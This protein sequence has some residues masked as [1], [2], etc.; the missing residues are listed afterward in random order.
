MKPIFKCVMFAFVFAC[1]LCPAWAQE[2]E[3]PQAGKAIEATPEPSPAADSETQPEASAEAVAEPSAEPKPDAEKTESAAAEGDDFSLDSLDELDELEQLESLDEAE[4]AEE[5]Q[6]KFFEINGYFRLRADLFHNIDLGIYDKLRPITDLPTDN[7]NINDNSA[8]DPFRRRRDN[9]IASTNMRLRLSPI[10]NISEDIKI[11]M[12]IDILDN[13]VLGTTPD[14]YRHGSPGTAP[15]IAG[16]SSSQVPPRAGSNSHTDSIEVKRVWAEVRTPFGLIKFGRMPSHWGTGM[17]INDGNCLDCDYGDTVDRILFGTK[18]F[19]HVLFFGYDFPNEGLTNDSNFEYGGQNLD[20]TQL[21]DVTQLVFGFARKHSDAEAEELIENNDF[22]IDYGFYNVIRWQS[23]SLESWDISPYGDYP[24]AGDPETVF[25]EQ[26]MLR[27]K[28]IKRNLKVYIGDLWFKFL[29][30]R[31]H[32]ETEAA[33]LNGRIGS[34]QLQSGGGDDESDKDSLQ[35]NQYGWVLQADYKFL[36]DSLFVGAE[37]GWAS[38]DPYHAQELEIDSGFGVYPMKD[39]QYANGAYQRTKN[40]PYLRDRAVENFRF[41]PD[42]I[43]DMI[44]FREIIGTVTNA[45]YLKPTIQYNITPSIGVR[46]D[47]IFSWALEADSTP[48][49]NRAKWQTQDEVG[50]AS[51]PPV[52]RDPSQWLGFELDLKVFYESFDGFGSSLQYGVFFPGKA[53]GYLDQYASG[54]ARWYYAPD[55]AQS[56]QWHLWVEF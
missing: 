18:L 10:F 3:Q 33:W 11:R 40:G 36:D 43:V 48:S 53:F 56:L 16:F 39:K 42:Y 54:G 9:T 22:V 28:F 50:V 5:E 25:G 20:A 38:G 49:Y 29:W 7:R 19:E 31:L 17:Y 13:V 2:N 30:K 12:D 26:K 55:I 37:W 21:D 45:T 15:G 32:I 8:N 23:Y 1:F 4:L 41:D 14:T 44:L 6:L 51:T 46:A 27:N 35:I 47:M 24:I 34:A 52:S